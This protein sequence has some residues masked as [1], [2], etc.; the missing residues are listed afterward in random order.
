MRPRRNDSGRREARGNFAGG[1]DA[2]LQR[3]HDAIGT[4]M[5][6]QSIQCTR[7]IAGLDAE[8][9]E[10]GKIPHI[11]PAKGRDGKCDDFALAFDQQ[12]PGPYLRQARTPCDDCHIEPRLCALRSDVA[13]DGSC[14]DDK[15]GS[16]ARDFAP[17]DNGGQ[18]GLEIPPPH[19]EWALMAGP[20]E[21][22]RKG[23][24]IC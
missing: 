7:Q 9:H 19:Q 17:H 6:L 23:G 12:A 3:K 20:A 10:F 5:R 18:A 21:V 24:T 4:D 22:C 13:A 1:I 11:G 16:H 2:V 8:D 15:N 14:A